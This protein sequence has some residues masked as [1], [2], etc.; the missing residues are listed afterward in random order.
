MPQQIQNIQESLLGKKFVYKEL[1]H[2]G[3][4]KLSYY[5]STVLT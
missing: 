1:V 5:V 4:S 3:K 2:M